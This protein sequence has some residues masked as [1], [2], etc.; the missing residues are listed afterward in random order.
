MCNKH[1]IKETD[2]SM[3]IV[4]DHG[5]GDYKFDIVYGPTTLE[6]AGYYCGKCPQ[7]ELI[8]LKVVSRKRPG[9][10]K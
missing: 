4:A 3:W 6:D 10:P 7:Y 5:K 9:G 1:Y 8:E 2:N